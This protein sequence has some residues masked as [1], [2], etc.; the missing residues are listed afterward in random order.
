MAEVMS[1]QCL[2]ENSKAGTEGRQNARPFQFLSHARNGGGGGLTPSI[3][4]GAMYYVYVSRRTLIE[5]EEEGRRAC[6]GVGGGIYFLVVEY[7]FQGMQQLRE[8]A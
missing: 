3:R 7:G 8:R 2:L 6:W 4:E 5:I 1:M